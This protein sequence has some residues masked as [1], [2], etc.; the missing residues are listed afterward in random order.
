MILLKHKSGTIDDKSD[1]K[2]TRLI[3][4][5]ISRMIDTV[6]QDKRKYFGLRTIGYLMGRCNITKSDIKE[7]GL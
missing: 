5:K 4:V 2:I 6:P 7:A 1:Y 3:Y